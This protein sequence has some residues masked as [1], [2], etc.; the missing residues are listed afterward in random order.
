MT[1]K[2]V[3]KISTL[4][5]LISLT[6]ASAADQKQWDECTQTRES[7]LSIGACTKVLQA[8][9]ETPSNRAIAYYARAGAHKTKGDYDQA[10]AD[11]TK[12]IEANPTYADAYAARG[13]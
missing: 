8:S 6:A 9:D 3:A 11:Y 7:D 2:R 10:I 1:P 12:A 5:L 13:I 4:L